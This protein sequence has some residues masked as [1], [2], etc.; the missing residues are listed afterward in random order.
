MWRTLL[1]QIWNRNK[2]K[3]LVVPAANIPN[4]VPSPDRIDPDKPLGG[5]GK[6]PAK[7][8]SEFMKEPSQG[9]PPPGAEQVGVNKPSPAELMQKQPMASEPPT[10]E[11]VNTQISASS[12]MLGDLQNKLNTPNL[13]LKSSQRYLIGNK[14]G[15]ANAHIRSAASQV[16][17]EL[18]PPPKISRQNPIARFVSMVTDGQ[19]QLNSLSENI[20]KMHQS[21]SLNPGQ[22][23]L[24]Q[25]KLNK[26]QQEIEYSSIIVSKAADDVKTMFNIQI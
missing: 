13:K 14:F 1:P 9:A 12:G 26:A 20:A 10:F 7:D 3:G 22:L 6:E 4:G 16:G 23:L 15:E 25:V 17:V 18:P 19:N 11:S 8:F 5:P 24:M 2:S 21:G